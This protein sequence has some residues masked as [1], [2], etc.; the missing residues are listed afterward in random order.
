MNIVGQIAR[1]KTGPRKP[2]TIANTTAFPLH[3]HYFSFFNINSIIAVVF[4]TTRTAVTATPRFDQ[5][6]THPPI[7]LFNPRQFPVIPYFMVPLRG[8]QPR[9]T[10]R[11]FSGLECLEKNFRYYRIQY[12]I[13]IGIFSIQAVLARYPHAGWNWFD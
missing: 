6:N 7:P 8:I 12:Q 4:S 10:G 13:M 2:K 5:E 11:F 9:I 1:R 3:S